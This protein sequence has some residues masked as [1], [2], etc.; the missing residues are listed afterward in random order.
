MPISDT[1]S[2]QSNDP[3]V[4][5]AFAALGHILEP[6]E[7]IDLIVPAVGCMIA[8]T[9]RRLAVVRDGAESRPRSGIASYPI[10]PSLMVRLGKARR[11]V[12]IEHQ[13]GSSSVFIRSV[14]FDQVVALIAA[15]NQRTHLD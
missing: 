11:H 9:D 5:A 13:C 7:Q 14:D 1:G 10:G 15:V 8:L 3:S 6:D 12:V 2:D 4:V